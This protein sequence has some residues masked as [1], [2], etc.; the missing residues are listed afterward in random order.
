MT[1]KD[2]VKN[3]GKTWCEAAYVNALIFLHNQKL[4]DKLYLMPEG[5][6]KDYKPWTMNREEQ[7]KYVERKAKRVIIR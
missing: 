2:T 6:F 5:F 3:T 4:T 7:R 1:S